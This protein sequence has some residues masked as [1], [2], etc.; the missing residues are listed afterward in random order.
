VT[1]HTLIYSILHFYS[2]SHYIKKMS[3]FCSY[4]IFQNNELKIRVSIDKCFSKYN[5]LIV[6]VDRVVLSWLDLKIS[7]KSQFLYKLSSPVPGTQVKY[8]WHLYVS[9]LP[10]KQFYGS[11]SGRI[12]TYLVGSGYGHLGTDPDPDPRLLKWHIFSLSCAE[13]FYEYF[14]IHVYFKNKVYI[15]VIFEKNFVLVCKKVCKQIL[16]ARIRIRLEKSDPESSTVV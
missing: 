5:L 14:K 3:I 15:N 12:G 8:I 10:H 13:K 6:L 2:I 9:K 4:S 16:L 11:G 7:Y 1:R